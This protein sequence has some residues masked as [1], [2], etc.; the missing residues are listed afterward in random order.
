MFAVLALCI[1]MANLSVVM[2]NADTPQVVTMAQLVDGDVT[3]GRYISVSGLAAYDVGYE[4]TENGTTKTVYYFLINPN[5]GDMVLVK[6]PTVTITTQEVDNVTVTGMTRFMPADLKDLLKEDEPLFAQNEVRTTSTLYLEDGA[7]PPSESGSITTI[8]VG[9]ICASLC[10]IPFLFPSI[11]FA[12]YPLDMTAALPT[13]RFDVKATGKFIQ[14]KS[15]DPLAIGKNKRNFAN[16]IANIIRVDENE[17]MI[18]IH[19]ILKTRTYGITVNTSITDWGIFLNKNTVSAVESGK[20]FGW[21][22]KW[23]VRF[24]Y[25]NAKGKVETLY[26]VLDD[27]GAQ[28]AFVKLLQRMLFS[29][30]TGDMA[31]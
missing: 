4:Q 12:P 21:K 7:T 31:A 24:Q 20:I 30:V 29:V 11:V 5:T 27:A 17:L 23:A 14:L 22:N 18:Y 16:A 8:V 9:L 26:V 15:L 28:V 19:H 25:P 3:T 10:S 1:G 13:E 2:D 6:H